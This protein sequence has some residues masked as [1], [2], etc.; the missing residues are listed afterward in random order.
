MFSVA[1]EETVDF[2][3]RGIFDGARTVEREIA[4][5]SNVGMAV[6]MKHRQASAVYKFMSKIAG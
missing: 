6:S 4:G 3:E 1:V 2:I 5:K